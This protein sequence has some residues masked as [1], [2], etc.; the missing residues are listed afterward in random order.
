MW[1]EAGHD[2]H[3]LERCIVAMGKNSTCTAVPIQNHPHQ[4]KLQTGSNQYEVR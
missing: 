4:M 3:K 1:D 2:P